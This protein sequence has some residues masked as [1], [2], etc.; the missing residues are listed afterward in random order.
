MLNKVQR[1]QSL[2]YPSGF[3]LLEVSNP[4]SGDNPTYPLV[5]RAVPAVGESFYDARFGTVLTRVTETEGINGRHEYSRFDPFNH[6]QSMILLDPNT[7]TVYRTSTLPYNQESNRVAQLNLSE[8]RWDPVDPDLIWGINEFSIYTYRFSTAQQ[9]QIEDFRTDPT[10]GPIIARA[11]LYRITMMDG[12]ESSLDK[13]YWAFALQGDAS[14]NYEMK[15]IFTWDRQS[16]RVMGILPIAPSETN[17]DWV[18]MS[19]LGNWVLIGGAEGNGGN[20]TYDPSFTPK[21]SGVRV[22]HRPPQYIP[23]CY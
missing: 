7:W 19:V 6:D 2:G 13:R 21:M 17:L 4:L 23:C 5:P 10:I 22:P 11:H 18:G 3:A 9:T 15:Y 20:L 1:S 16:D 14:E 8:P 12:G